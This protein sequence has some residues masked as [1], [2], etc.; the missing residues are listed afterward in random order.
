MKKELRDKIAKLSKEQIKRVKEL[1]PLLKNG[2]PVNGNE[3]IDLYNEVFGRDS[4]GRLKP[5]TGCG[6]CLRRYLKIMVTLKNKQDEANKL[7]M[8]KAREAK[9][10]KKEETV[11]EN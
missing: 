9:A 11:I 1:E 5:Y 4:K 7:R 8:Q 6:S 3:I 2:R 10:M